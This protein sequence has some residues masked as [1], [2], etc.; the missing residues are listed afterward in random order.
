M[1]LFPKDKMKSIYGILTIYKL[2]KWFHKHTNSHSIIILI[3]NCFT[4][5]IQLIDYTHF[6]LYLMAGEPFSS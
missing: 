6:D 4:E 5:H 1:Q 3:I 2:V